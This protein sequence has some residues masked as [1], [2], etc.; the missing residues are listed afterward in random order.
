MRKK[1]LSALTASFRSLPDPRVDRTKHHVLVDIMAIA[2]CA[3]V[4]GADG[5]TEVEDFG[6]IK[7]K[8]L[9]RFL[10][11]PHGIPSHDTFGRVFAAL[12]PEAFQACF[13]R[14]VQRVAHLTTGQV[15]AID[16]K[17]LRRSHDAAKNKDA[18]HLVSAWATAN[19]L[20]LGQVKVADKSN[21]ITA[22]P[23]LLQLLDVRGCL[24]TIDAAGTQTKIAATILDRQ[25]DYLLALK[26]NQKGLAEDVQTLY[27]WAHSIKFADLQHD[28]ARTVSKGHGRVEIRECWTISDPQFL[29]DL[30]QGRKWKGLHSVAQIRAERRIGDKVTVETRYYISSLA[31]D[32][33]QVLAASRS[34]WE[35]ENSLHWVLD[36]AMNE[37]ACR[38]RQ[39]NAD[40]NFAV[41]RHLALNLLRQEKTA[42]AGIK[43]K[44]LRAGWDES[45]LVTILETA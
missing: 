25:A 13:V 9:K 16:G 21:E 10:A 6:K 41:L 29:G 4:C 17:T 22:I 8:W 5:W 1:P 15:I 18:I 7:K 40:A 32:A 27:E 35:V 24:V 3:V 19:R 36:V 33:H 26:K 30:R 39:G 31:G 38:V 28:H 11:L 2:I 12:D 45:Y 34:H 14:W 44:R 43:G 42:K 23:E 37:D 20:V